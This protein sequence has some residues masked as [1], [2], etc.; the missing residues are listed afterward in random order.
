MTETLEWQFGG[1]LRTLPPAAAWCVLAVLAAAGLVFVVRLYRRTLRALPPA[2]R[3]SLTLFRAAIVLAVLLCLADPARVARSRPDH[4]AQD[5]LAVLVD[6]S[7]SMTGADYRGATRLASAVRT[8]KE[9]E[10][11]AAAAFPKITY[12]RFA[13]DVKAA[14]SM[15]EALNAP[16]P[17]PETHLYSALEKT[18]A[19]GPRA[20]V[21]LTDGLDTTADAAAPLVEEAQRQGVCIYFVSGSNRARAGELVDIREVKAPP[22]VLRRTQFAAGALLE[23]SALEARELPVELWSGAKKLASTRLQLRPGLNTLP[24]TVP[25]TAGEPGPMPL[26][27]RVGEGE[28][29]QTAACTTQV[30]DQTKVEV[31]YYQGA[32]QWGYSYLRSALE[33]DASFHMTAILNP[34]LRVRLTETEEG[35]AA[36]DDLPGTATELKRFQIIVLAHAFVDQFTPEQQRALL[37]YVRGG[38][39]VLFISPDDQAAAR[40]AGTD[41]EKMLPVVFEPAAPEDDQAEAEQRFREQMM[42]ARQLGETSDGNIRNERHADLPRLRPF[43]VPPGADRSATTAIFEGRDRASLP[44]FCRYAKVRGA[45]PGAS[46]LSISSEDEEG[47]PPQILLARQQFGDGFAAALTT[48]LLWRWKMSLPSRSH[49]VEKFWQQLLLSL[50]PAT[51]AGLRLVKLT[52]SAANHTPVQFRIDASSAGG[53]PTAETV[54]PTGE[55]KPLDLQKTSDAGGWTASFTPGAPGHWEVRATDPARNLSRLTFPVTE[56]AMTT[57]TLNLPPDLEGMRRLAESTGGALIGDEPVFEKSAVTE[58]A[59]QLQSVQPMW[60]SSWLLGLLLGLYGTEL[61]VRRFFRLL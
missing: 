45:K 13:V 20:I 19:T 17:G 38:G 3:W 54:S 15:D 50:A 51:G 44:M 16:G 30:T 6:R 26:E 24:W 34:A 57:E 33:T 36:L 27:F 12:Q 49:A 2:A 4:S 28:Q 58:G 11:E 31:L 32:L 39:A 60:H 10:G 21:C 7:G 52:E 53:A 22:R 23:V 18:L 47:T 41:I 61:V 5:T 42:D 25:V 59:P 43:A 9:H 29:Q 46:I 14:K 37:E 1:W 35:H 40:Y 56:K 55:H 48:D 8:W